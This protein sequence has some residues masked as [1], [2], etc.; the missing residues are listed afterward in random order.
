[1]VEQCCESCM[2]SWTKWFLRSDVKLGEFSNVGKL[3]ETVQFLEN[4]L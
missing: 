2:E 1:M 3:V 4:I